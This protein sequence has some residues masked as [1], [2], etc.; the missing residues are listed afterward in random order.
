MKKMIN[1]YYTNS[2]AK[3]GVPIILFALTF[4]LLHHRSPHFHTLPQNTHN[5]SVPIQQNLEKCDFFVGDWVAYDGEPLYNKSCGFIN[6]SNQNCMESGRPDSDYLHWRWKP[7]ACHLTRFDPLRFLEIMRNKR[8]AFVGDSISRNHIQSLLCMLSTVEHATL[9]YHD[10]SSQ[11]QTWLFPSYNLTTS[12]IWS[13]FLAK[14]NIP[15]NIYDASP[16]E[17]D[18]HLDT[19]DPS[20][21]D[22]FKTWDYTIFSAGKWY[23]RSS[24]YYQ[25]DTVLGC[26]YC[27]KRNLTDIGF[28]SAYR[29]VIRGVLDYIVESNHTGTVFYRTTSPSHFEGAEW[30]DGG[31]CER[32]GPVKE[33]EF[34]LSWLD[35]I[36]RDIEIEEFG[37]AYVVAREKGVKLRVLDVNPMSLLRP[38]GHPG[39]FRVSR[40]SAGEG[41]DAK[42]VSDCLHWCLPGPIDSWNDVLM[43]MVVNG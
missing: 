43:E 11:S 15:Q 35:K 4:M 10:E 19:L 13:P 6:G 12:V 41:K 36:L 1:M 39:A 42:V 26:H 23:S 16:S 25:N 22:H 14:A 40:S 32:K 20:W 37:R 31:V 18:V 9:I 38:D 24:I 28:D 7:R 34:G 5:T 29:R 30:Y 3:F 33:G 2:V 8:W 17:V 21:T 27:P